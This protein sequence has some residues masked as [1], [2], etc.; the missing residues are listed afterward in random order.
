[1]W[2]APFSIFRLQ[3]LVQRQDFQRRRVVIDGCEGG[4]AADGSEGKSEKAAQVR[5]D[6]VLGH[7]HAAA[8]EFDQ[9]TL[10]GPP[11]R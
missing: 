9:F 7:K 5:V 3:A 1:V 2:N 10:A 11:L 6:W 8:S 4:L